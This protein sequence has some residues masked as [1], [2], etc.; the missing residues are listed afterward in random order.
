MSACVNTYVYALSGIW[1]KM[2]TKLNSLHYLLNKYM[3][4]KWISNI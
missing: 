1:E 2:Q 4:N 3:L